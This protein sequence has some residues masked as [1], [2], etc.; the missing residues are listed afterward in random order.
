MRVVVLPL[1]LAAGPAWAEALALPRS[2]DV[3][4]PDSSVD[5]PAGPGRDVAVNNCLACHSGDFIAVQPPQPPAVWAAE[6]AKMRKVMKAPVSD[7]DAATIVAYLVAV[8]GIR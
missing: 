2:V 3:T 1:L 8:K 7:A 4:L 5:L 6:V